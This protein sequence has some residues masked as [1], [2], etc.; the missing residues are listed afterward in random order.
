MTLVNSGTKEMYKEVC[1]LIRVKPKYT[2]EFCI[3]ML[4]CKELCNRVSKFKKVAKIKEAF[5][6]LGPF[7]FLLELS[8][9]K[10]LFSYNNKS[11]YVSKF[12]EFLIKDFD[13]SW[14]EK[15]DD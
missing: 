14:V 4:A 8:E 9:K 1:V 13:A 5:S 2:E 7:D 10:Y 11:N 6:V 3:M 15:I 12:K